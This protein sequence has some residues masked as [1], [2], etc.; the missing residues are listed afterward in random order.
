[1]APTSYCNMHFSSLGNS[2]L[3]CSLHLKS[4][5]MVLLA[6]LSPTWG[7]LRT[8]SLNGKLRMKTMNSF[9]IRPE[10]SG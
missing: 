5:S 7:A 2:S 1:M 6:M 3:A 9:R 8:R 10:S 4:K